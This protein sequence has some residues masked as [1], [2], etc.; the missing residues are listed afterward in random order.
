MQVGQRMLEP[1]KL[2]CQWKAQANERATIL[3]LSLHIFWNPVFHFHD[4][5]LL[6]HY[7]S[8]CW[9]YHDA[10]EYPATFLISFGLFHQWLKDTS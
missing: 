1:L 3:H 6:T 2:N 4:N 5:V 10:L 7:W 9:Y 8:K